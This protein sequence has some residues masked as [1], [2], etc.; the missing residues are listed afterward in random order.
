[1]LAEGELARGVIR[2]DT[3]RNLTTASSFAVQQGTEARGVVRQMQQRTE[4]VPRQNKPDLSYMVVTF[5]VDSYDER[6]N[7]TQDSAGADP[8]PRI[9]GSSTTA[10]TSRRTDRS[11]KGCCTAASSPT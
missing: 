8:G 3:V 5:L 6:G 10:T 9:S 4:Q 2:C 1:M 7:R 11:P